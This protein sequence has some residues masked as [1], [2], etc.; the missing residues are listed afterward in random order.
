M[1]KIS[2][3]N[4]QDQLFGCNLQNLKKR[5]RTT[6]PPDTDNLIYHF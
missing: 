4:N 5:H 3:S 6:R 1:Q 2:F